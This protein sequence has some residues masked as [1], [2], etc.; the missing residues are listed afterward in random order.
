MF[1]LS[2]R[3]KSLT[4]TH[5]A[6][7]GHWVGFD[8]ESDGHR[9][10]CADR[11]TVGIERSIIFERR[12]DVAILTSV[13]TQ[14][15]GERERLPNGSNSESNGDNADTNAPP[16]E[17]VHETSQRTTPVDH[18]PSHLGDAFKPPPPEPALRRSTRQCFESEY[19][20]CLNAGEGT[21]DGRTTHP[22]D[23]AKTAIEELFEGTM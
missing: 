3:P 15:V 6:R 17:P 14:P 13:S 18:V 8:P 5:S 12:S 2:V 4:L 21:T 23:M 11:G 10:Y 19:F 20:K 9:I 16:N 7:D 22:S 1:G